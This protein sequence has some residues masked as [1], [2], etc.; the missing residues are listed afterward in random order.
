M[1]DR[2]LRDFTKE[3]IQKLAGTV[4][5]WRSGAYEDISGF[6]K[7][8]LQQEIVSHG[9]VLTPGRF[10]GAEDVEEEGEAF[11]DKMSR[12]AGELRVHFVES[13]KLEQAIKV[14]LEGLGYGG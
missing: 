9:H 10:V 2:V 5:E 8:G 4:R 13:A 12:L 14:N 1:K 6:C 3:D 11:E 7:S